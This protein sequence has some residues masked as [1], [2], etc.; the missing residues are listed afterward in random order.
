VLLLVRKYSSLLNLI[1]ALT[2]IVFSLVGP[3]SA[4]ADIFPEAEIRRPVYST[5]REVIDI[6]KLRAQIEDIDVE[7]ADIS[8]GT[9]VRYERGFSEFLMESLIEACG[10]SAEFQTFSE[11]HAY[12]ILDLTRSEEAFL[13][14]CLVKVYEFADAEIAILAP[15]FYKRFSSEYVDLSIRYGYRCGFRSQRS[16]VRF[17]L[18]TRLVHPSEIEAEHDI[19]CIERLSSDNSPPN[20]RPSKSVIEDS[21]TSIADKYLFL[22]AFFGNWEDVLKYKAYETVVLD[23]RDFKR[24]KELIEDFRAD[25][26]WPIEELVEGMTYLECM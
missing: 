23:A 24:C 8:S 12:E 19:W 20:R 3:M 1:S 11:F 18:T 15:G 5:D 13:I 26:D 6:E 22:I 7:D 14:D 9:I 16:F 2:V 21:L 17:A 25:G 10:H 4:S